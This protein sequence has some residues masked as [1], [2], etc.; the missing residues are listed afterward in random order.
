MSRD[1]RARLAKLEGKQGSNSD[2]DR[3]TAD[4]VAA[5]LRRLL[6]QPG[7]RAKFMEAYPMTEAQLQDLEDE[8]AETAEDLS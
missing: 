5:E 6:T 8:L 4:E 7:M 3:M 1:L 2:V